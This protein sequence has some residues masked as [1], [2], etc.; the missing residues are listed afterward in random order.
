MSRRSWSTLTVGMV[1]CA[2]SSAFVSAP[3]PAEASPGTWTAVASP[4][5]M[6]TT[7]PQ[8]GPAVLPDGRVLV[9][10]S[11]A[12]GTPVVE[13]YDPRSDRWARAS[14]TPAGA[15]R[16]VTALPNGKVLFQCCTLE[17]P[18]LYDPAR[19]AWSF[20]APPQY[21]RT[22]G[23]ATA[24]LNDGR[25]LV[26]GG[27]NN[28]GQSDSTVREATLKSAEVYDFATDSWSLTGPLVR[29]RSIPTAVTLRDGRVLVAEG[30]TAE[31]FDPASGTWRDAAPPIRR[32]EGR[33]AI[34]LADGRALV[35][36]GGTAQLYD[37]RGSWSSANSCAA[38]GYA[39]VLPSGEVLVLGP[40]ARL[41]D[42][43]SDSCMPVASPTIGVTAAVLLT[44]SASQCGASCGKVLAIGDGKAQ[45]WTPGPEVSTLDPPSGP[46]GT[47]VT[48]S[49]SGFT[50][51]STT[52]SFGGRPGADVRV[53]SPT[54]LRVVAPPHEPGPVE[55]RV[56]TEGGAS[57]VNSAS[58]FTYVLARPAVTRIDP[59]TGAEDGGTTVSVIG[60]ALTGATAVSFGD[61]AATSFRVESDTQVT[62]VTPVHPPGTVDVVVT[63]PGGSAPPSAA[64][65][66][67]FLAASPPGRTGLDGTPGAGTGGQQQQSPLS[68]TGP[69]GG[70]P[71]PADAF[72]SGQPLGANTSQAFGP[73]APAPLNPGLAGGAVPT[74]AAPP[75]PGLAVPPGVAPSAPPAVVPVPGAVAQSPTPGLAGGAQETP[76]AASGFAM[77]RRDEAAATTG[78]A[79]GG[80]AVAMGFFWCCARH[81]GR[82][83]RSVTATARQGGLAFPR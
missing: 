6:A 71:A 22:T 43:E 69:A 72:A 17:D 56:T 52:V 2:A 12:A 8:G 46:A 82:E 13:L 38:A 66:F 36:G 81:Q 62:A 19:D 76:E 11:T 24:Q 5:V 77:V 27:Q 57:D 29:P 33:H 14:G 45:L 75:V 64:T 42:P 30:D 37:P 15:G 51:G 25:V 58:R 23:P 20:A 21:T 68:P 35:S 1:L 47:T 32:V 53:L 28:L 83:C 49:G 78:I 65:R 26:I 39:T 7:G 63:T 16:M 40:G 50:A 79:L 10:G 70:G 31:L 67:T 18:E 9:L 3:R 73:G 60:T 4:T 61:V 80:A 34:P 48:I 55:V 74:A 59:A 41:Y 44:G 54:S